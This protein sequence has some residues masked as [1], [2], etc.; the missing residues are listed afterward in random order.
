MADEE[1]APAEVEEKKRG[2]GLAIM[3][4]ILAG[5]LFGGI[6]VFFLTRDNAPQEATEE[7]AAV[8]QVKPEQPPAD[9]LVVRRRRFAVP[10]INAEG[11]SLG[12]MWVD[13]A[14]EVDGPN[15][16]SLVS[17]RLPSLMDAY[18]RDLHSRQTTREDRP[19]A[20]DFDL[21]QRRLRAVTDHMLG[22]NRVLGIRI[23]NAMRA[24]G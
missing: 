24:P 17:S 2:P 3:A 22:E 10:L 14:F 5:L 11:E 7:T 15:N 19:G 23:T 6:G 8:E 1:L 16:Q 4:G 9:L 20:M 21:L 18:L 12:Y 13:L